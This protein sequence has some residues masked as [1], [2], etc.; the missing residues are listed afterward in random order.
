MFY[1]L[2]LGWKPWNALRINWEWKEWKK[3]SKGAKTNSIQKMTTLLS[4]F[5]KISLQ[6]K[7]AVTYSESRKPWD[8]A[9]ESRTWRGRVTPL[10]GAVVLEGNTP[11]GSHFWD[12]KQGSK[13]E[14]RI[15]AVIVSLFF[16]FLVWDHISLFF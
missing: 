9:I 8:W 3:E 13:L 16:S 10:W 6:R 15:S 5:R 14:L 1:F 12:I 4:K 2:L 11:L 7:N